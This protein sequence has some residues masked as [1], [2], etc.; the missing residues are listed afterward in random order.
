[1]RAHPF[2]PPHGRPFR[3]AWRCSG[4]GLIGLREPVSLAAGKLEHGVDAYLGTAETFDQAIV[5]FGRAYAN[6][7]ELDCSALREAAKAGRVTSD[8]TAG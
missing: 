6:Q 5:A 3:I 4:T 2:S 1:M 8:P 7:N